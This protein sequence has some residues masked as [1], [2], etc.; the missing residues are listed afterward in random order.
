M[1]ISL[2]QQIAEIDR[3]LRMRDEVYPGLVARRKLRQ[4][5][6][7]LHVARLRAVRDTLAWVRENEDTIK[8]VHAE[9][10]AAAASTEVA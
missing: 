10:H 3:E 9:L 2:D 1:K 7:D 5:E 6:A 8:R 4:A